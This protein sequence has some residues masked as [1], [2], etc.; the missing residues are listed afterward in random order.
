MKHLLYTFILCAIMQSA[1]VA[2]AMPDNFD[3]MLKE[4]LSFSVPTV[5]CEQAK[6]L[7]KD[8]NALFLDAR[9]LPEYRVSHL[10]SARHI[11]YDDFKPALLADIPKNTPIVLYC[12][13]GY[14][15]EKIGEKLQKMGYTK[16]YNLYGSIFQ[17]VNEGE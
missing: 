12:S 5:T 8:K 13:V 10:P 4:L 11:G 9:E 7:Q 6:I 17:W 15:S 3:K 2:Q 1:A 16:V 14:R